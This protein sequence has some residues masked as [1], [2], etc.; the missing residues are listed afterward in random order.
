MPGDSAERFSL[1]G[2]RHEVSFGMPF[3]PAHR[4]KFE[5]NENKML[6]LSGCYDII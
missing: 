2:A 4:K 5:K 3:L 6:T 1:N